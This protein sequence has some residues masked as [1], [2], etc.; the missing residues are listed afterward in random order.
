MFTNL[1]EQQN[2]TLTSVCG[3]TKCSTLVAVS[4]E[5]VYTNIFFSEILVKSYIVKHGELN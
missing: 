4:G 3:K 2:K 1:E 5:T